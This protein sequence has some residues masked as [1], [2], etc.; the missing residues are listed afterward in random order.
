MDARTRKLT[1]SRHPPHTLDEHS[2]PLPEQVLNEIAAELAKRAPTL[3][4]YVWLATLQYY[5][6]GT[7]RAPHRVDLPA[8]DPGCP[9]CLPVGLD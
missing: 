5:Y 8:L 7:G 2:S 3:V 4:G 1:D 6:D 9:G